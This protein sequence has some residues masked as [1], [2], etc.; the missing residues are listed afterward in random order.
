[1]K[2]KLHTRGGNT[3][4]V[5]GDRTLYDELVEILLS[6]RQPNW[7]KTPSGTI[8]LSEIIAITKEK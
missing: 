3:I 2:L 8:N 5:Q 1:M 6:G 7:V 4:T